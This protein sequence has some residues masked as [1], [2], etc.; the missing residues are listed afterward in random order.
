MCVDFTL[1]LPCTGA[2]FNIPLIVGLEKSF[3][4]HS[5]SCFFFLNF[6]FFLL[7]FLFPLFMSAWVVL[8][9]TEMMKFV[10]FPGTLCLGH[11]GLLMFTAYVN[12]YLDTL[13]WYQEPVWQISSKCWNVTPRWHLLPGQ[14][15]IPFPESL[16]CEQVISHSNKRQTFPHPP[17]FLFLCLSLFAKQRVSPINLCHRVEWLWPPTYHSGTNI[18]GEKLA[19]TSVMAT[20]GLGYQAQ[21]TGPEV[22]GK[23]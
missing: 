19:G 4:D 2:Y 9:G 13:W 8:A 23:L 17:P 22:R 20:K 16:T 10:T 7:C 3:N 15:G 21:S 14:Q 18:C 11:S 6:V 12:A 1:H 5:F